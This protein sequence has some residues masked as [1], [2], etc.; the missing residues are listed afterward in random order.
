MEAAVSTVSQ[1]ACTEMRGAGAMR[2]SRPAKSAGA[3]SGQAAWLA[4]FIILI[5]RR[6]LPSSPI[7]ATLASGY[8]V[9]GVTPARYFSTTAVRR[10]LKFLRATTVSRTG[11]SR[12]TAPFDCSRLLFLRLVAAFRSWRLGISR[13]RKV[14]E[15]VPI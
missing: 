3:L 4:G 11:R 5:E 9:A 7:F 13:L 8:C 10:I 1:N 14:K 15:S 6:H 12:R 2:S